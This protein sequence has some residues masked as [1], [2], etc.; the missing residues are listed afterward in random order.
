MKEKRRRPT[1]GQMHTVR[2]ERKARLST[3]GGGGGGVE[4]GEAECLVTQ[5]V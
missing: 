4:G 2:E 5:V 3:K 1:D